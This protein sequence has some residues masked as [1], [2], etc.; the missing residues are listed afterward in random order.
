MDP[1]RRMSDIDR[2][3]FMARSPEGHAAKSMKIKDQEEVW[4][5][6]QA[7]T[8]KN[9]ANVILREA[10]GPTV[11]DLETGLQDG[12][13]LVALVESLQK[14][15]LKHNKRP[16]NQHQELENISIAIDAILEDGL[17]LVNIGRQRFP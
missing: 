17:K 15:K 16:I 10:G 7:D 5:R 9:W 2:A 12:T 4:V 8:F 14:R 6:I 11:D 1:M 3:G 13:K